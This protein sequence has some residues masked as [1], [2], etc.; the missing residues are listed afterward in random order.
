MAEA[1]AI[2]DYAIMAVTY[3]PSEY[4]ARGCESM[5]GPQVNGGDQATELLVQ[6]VW[7][8]GGGRLARFFGTLEH[9][10]V[11]PG[12]FS[13]MLDQTG[14]SLMLGAKPN[15]PTNLISTTPTTCAQLGSQFD[16]RSF[17]CAPVSLMR[18]SR[19]DQADA[20]LAALIESAREILRMINAFLAGSY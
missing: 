1:N 8:A 4:K 19:I 15:S 2:L 13:I 7:L 9:F 16:S 11:M 14:Q 3:E 20:Q 12:L 6:D 18:S 5:Q 17:P 10:V